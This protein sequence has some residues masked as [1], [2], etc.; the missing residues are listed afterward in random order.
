[1]HIGIDIDDVTANFVDEFRAYIEK[2]HQIYV[3][4]EDM[5]TYHMGD[6]WGGTREE[7]VEY[8]NKFGETPEFETM[9]LLAGAFEAITNLA[10]EHTITFVTA[11]YGPTREKT[12]IWLK[13][14]FPN[15]NCNLIFAE[16]FLQNRLSAKADICKEKKID[17]MIEDH[18]EYA[19]ECA[20]AGIT[21]LLLTQP[22]NK[23]QELIPNLIRAHNWQEIEKVITELNNL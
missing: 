22:W 10:K 16:S 11:R 1:M 15:M 2:E 13:N 14:S 8:V 9:G 4:K 20:R 5:K 23:N 3:K 18:P 6:A 17:I 21:T 7:V 12:P 19:S